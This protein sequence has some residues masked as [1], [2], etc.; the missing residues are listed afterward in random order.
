MADPKWG[1]AVKAF[2]VLRP[3]QETSQDELVKHCRT[4]IAGYKCPREIEFMAE[5]P[6]IASGKINKVA[7][8][9][10]QKT[11]AGA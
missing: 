4:L 10:L 5:L 11:R 3:N 1:E 6:R 9:D 8:R 7:L 2:V